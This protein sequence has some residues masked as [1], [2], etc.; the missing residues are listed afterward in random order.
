MNY[1]LTNFIK[2][3][4][5]T[6]NYEAKFVPTGSSMVT[7]S[8]QAGITIVSITTK[9]GHTEYQYEYVCE[10]TNLAQTPDGWNLLPIPE[11]F[12]VVSRDI[13]PQEGKFAAGAN[14]PVL[15]KYTLVLSN[16]P[17]LSSL[18][19]SGTSPMELIT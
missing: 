1:T 7:G 13:E 14:F 5:C 3:A 17:Y 8:V 9:R 4:V 2:R 15:Y 12:S 18:T 11:H 16:E 19:I 10:W 6:A